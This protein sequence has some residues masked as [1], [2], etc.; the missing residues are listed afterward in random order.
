MTVLDCYLTF[1]LCAAYFHVCWFVFI[2]RDSKK[3]DT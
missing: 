2:H 3:H 1:D